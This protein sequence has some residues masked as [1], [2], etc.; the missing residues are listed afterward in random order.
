MIHR[1]HFAALES[2]Y[3]LPLRRV[4]LGDRAIKP[5]VRLDGKEGG[6]PVRNEASPAA[7]L[8]GAWDLGFADDVENDL[9]GRDYDEL[10]TLLR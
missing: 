2:L 7:S 6:W 10:S 3:R 5:V 8:V 9:R 1:F 4:S